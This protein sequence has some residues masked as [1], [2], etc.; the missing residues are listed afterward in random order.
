MRGLSKILKERSP[1]RYQLPPPHRSASRLQLTAAL[2]QDKSEIQC[3]TNL[4]Q[5]NDIGIHILVLGSV[6]RNAAKLLKFTPKR[7]H[8]KDRFSIGWPPNL[9][10]VLSVNVCK[11][12][13]PK[14]NGKMWE[15]FPSRGPPPPPC[16]GIFSRFYRLFLGGLTC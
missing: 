9:L 15:F 1:G 2:I 12:R 16:L 5:I 6:D 7:F 10:R 4:T 13:L 8:V 3:L 11:G 14:K